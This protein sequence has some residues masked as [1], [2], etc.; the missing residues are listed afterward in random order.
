[1]ANVS[2]L[3][4]QTSDMP[5]I[6]YLIFK[7]K[8]FPSV[9]P[10]PT[11]QDSSSAYNHSNNSSYPYLVLVTRIDHNISYKEYTVILYSSNNAFL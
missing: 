10:V 1:M 8:G 7:L 9:F 2:C 3:V 4:S 6:R 5:S 11:L